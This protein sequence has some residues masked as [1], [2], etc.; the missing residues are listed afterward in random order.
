MSKQFNPVHFL[1]KYGQNQG[2]M[3][4]FNINVKLWLDK[5]PMENFKNSRGI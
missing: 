2:F 4:H 3:N 5:T 1:A